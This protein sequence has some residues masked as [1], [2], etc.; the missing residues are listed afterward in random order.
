MI[1]KFVLVVVLIGTITGYSDSCGI[2][3]WGVTSNGTETSWGIVACSDHW[4]FGTVFV[5]EDLGT[6]VCQDRGGLIQGKDQIDIWFP[7]RQE[8]LDHGVWRR[9][10]KVYL[11][12]TH[13]TWRRYEHL[14]R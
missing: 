2:S 5:I 12:V 6:F 4:P 11:P 14:I 8:A 3:P 13:W 1:T 9:W 7:S 10:V